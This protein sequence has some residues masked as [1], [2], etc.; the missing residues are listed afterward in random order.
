MD[1]VRACVEYAESKN[2][3]V[4]LIDED[5][6][7]SGGAGGKVVKDHPEHKQ[8]HLLFTPNLYGTV[9]APDG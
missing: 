2:M 4:C 9:P 6:Y 3:L 1:I 5:R 8:K 7:P